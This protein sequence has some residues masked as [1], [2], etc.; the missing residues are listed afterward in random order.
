MTLKSIVINGDTYNYYYP[1]SYTDR[2]LLLKQIKRV[3]E[4]IKAC[5]TGGCYHGK[6]SKLGI[7]WYNNYPILLEH[8]LSVLNKN[9]TI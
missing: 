6:V 4:K 9:E 8:L 7:P 2:K 5:Q 3:R 1:D